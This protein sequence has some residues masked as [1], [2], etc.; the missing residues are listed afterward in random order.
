MQW[1]LCLIGSTRVS[2]P[3]SSIR[4]ITEY[5][6]GPPPPLASPY[7]AGVGLI[8]RRLF[9]SIRVG[10]RQ[11]AARRRT[12]GLLFVSAAQATDCA[13]EIDRVVGLST[14]APVELLPSEPLWLQRTRS[15][16]RFL[17]VVAMRRS[18]GAA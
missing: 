15:G 12:A 8:D 2:V 14:E 4:L 9:L 16:E 6:V 1:L 11:S 10:F 5:E 3:T 18:L 17:D 7:L 13:F